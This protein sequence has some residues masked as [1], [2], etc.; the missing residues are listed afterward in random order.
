[1]ARHQR[2]KERPQAMATRPRQAMAPQRRKTARRLPRVVTMRRPEASLSVNDG[3][4]RLAL[5]CQS[6]RATPSK[7]SLLR[8]RVSRS[9]STRGRC[10]KLSWLALAAPTRMPRRHRKRE[11]TGDGDGETTTGDGEEDGGTATGGEEEETGGGKTTTGNV[12]TTAMGG[13]ETGGITREKESGGG[14]EEEGDLPWCDEDDDDDDDDDDE[15]EEADS[16]TTT[17]EDDFDGPTDLP[18]LTGTTTDEVTTTED[19]I[20]SES[21]DNEC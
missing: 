21:L 18:E 1:M 16:S 3:S 14:G 7:F 5:G 6:R 10:L 19:G 13:I 9:I 15:E 8:H 20:T 11:T 12:T 4:C 17:D 2:E